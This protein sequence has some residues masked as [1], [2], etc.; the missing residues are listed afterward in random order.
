MNKQYSFETTT[1]GFAADVL[2]T[3]HTVP[4]VVDFWAP[5]CGPCRALKPLLEK[6]VQEYRGG[7]LLAKINTDEHPEIA[8]HYGVRGIPNVKAFV[9]GKLAGEFTGVLPEMKLRE[10]VDAIIPGSGEKLRL[11]A[12]ADVAAGDFES[13]EIKLLEGL[14]H[15]PQNHRA[16]IDLAELLV[17][18][19]AFEQAEQV[20]D[21]LP[22]SHRD[23]RAEQIAQRIAL[24][25]KTNALPNAKRLWA[26]I[27]ASP[28]DLEA[29]LAYAD[30][31]IVDNDYSRAL[32][33]LLGVV[34]Q[35]DPSQRERARRAMIDVFNLAVQK[36]ELVGE[37]RRRL[38]S[39]LN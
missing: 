29:R 37:Y 3:S 35:G 26:K 32:E 2:E 30:R 36:P 12:K 16:R 28:N 5:W 14:K 9:G 8:A 13:A 34:E 1:A 4:V 33:V 39:V 22:A 23:D 31:L 10:F 7:F 25:R 27:E 38:A 21:A 6:L 24:W 15:A 20:M 17:A 11:A 19:H 18:R